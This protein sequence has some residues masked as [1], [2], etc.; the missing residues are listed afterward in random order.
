MNKNL[1]LKRAISVIA[2]IAILCLVLNRVYE[3]V[4]WKD[5]EGDY[6]STMKE[7][8]STPEDTMELVFVGSSHCYG[9]IDTEYFWSNYGIPAFNM[10]CSGQDKDSAYHQLKEL[11]KTQ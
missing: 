11:L 2:F 7:L 9:G 4:S 6:V 8:Y 10:C 3:I 5:T 1:I